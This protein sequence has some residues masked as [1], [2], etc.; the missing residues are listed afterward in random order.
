MKFVWIIQVNSTFKW[1][2]NDKIKLIINNFYKEAGHLLGW[3]FGL[4]SIF[5][6]TDQ[7]MWKL[8]PWKCWHNIKYVNEQKLTFE[9][10]NPY[11]F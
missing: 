3:T 9:K 8:K 11:T 4:N 6:W 1:V 7:C 5:H 2:H 10:A